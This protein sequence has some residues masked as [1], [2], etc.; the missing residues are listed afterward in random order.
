MYRTITLSEYVKRRNGVALGASG[1][2]TN[3]LKRSLGASSF[4]LFWQYW[5]PIWGYYLS[6][7]IMKPLSGLLPKGLAI[8]LTFAV[9]GALHD[10]AITLVKWEFTFYFTPWFILMSFM[11]IATKKFGIS[12]R[13]HHWLVRALINI[14]IIAV[15][16]VLTER[17]V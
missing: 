15:C 17:Y 9:S 5:N 7:N 4:Y 14:S 1:S 8:I 13:E 6:R 12:Y 10:A 16:L 11:V 3:M 2:M